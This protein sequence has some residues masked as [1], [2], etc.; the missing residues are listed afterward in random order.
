[1]TEYWGMEVTAPASPCLLTDLQSVKDRLGITD[2]SQDTYL[3]AQIEYLST[4]IA[5]YCERVFCSNSYTQTWET[6]PDT[7]FLWGRRSVYT[8]HTPI[9][10]L[11]SLT[12]N[13]AVVAD[14]LVIEKT[15][16][17]VAEE[18][19]QADTISIEYD[20]GYDPVPA[21]V[22]MAAQDMVVSRYGNQGSDPS[23]LV[24]SESVPEVGK[25][26]YV[27][28]TYY[29]RGFDPLIGNYG[30]LLDKYKT[31]RAYGLDASQR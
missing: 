13:G 23:K 15:G 22:A 11:T 5:N 1:M 9:I 12:V 8:V 14:P 17:I 16:Q 27:S 30:T 31:E 21:D 6:V 28:S 25:V 20:A 4:L 3:T 24:R 18:L 2:A 10:T 26:D 7:G 19:L 29:Q